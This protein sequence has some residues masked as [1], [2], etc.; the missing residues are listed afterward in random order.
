M[1]FVIGYKKKWEE[2]FSFQKII[3]SEKDK[4]FNYK[5]NNE[6]SICKLRKLL[7]EKNNFEE[8]N[9]EG[10]NLFDVNAF[11]IGSVNEIIIPNAILQSPFLNL[12][13]S[14]EYNLAFIGTTI[15]HELIHAFDD[16]GSKLDE[17]GNYY[18][19]WTKKDKEEYLKKQKEVIKKYEKMAS[20]DKIKLDG[21]LSLGEN[22]ADMFGLLLCEDVLEKYLLEKKIFGEKQDPY[23][24]RF[25]TY[26]S[27]SW[28][29]KMN[30]KYLKNR[31]LNDVHSLS[32]YRVNGVLSNSP[33]F[34]KVF[35]MNKSN[36][37]F[38]DDFIDIW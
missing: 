10:M 38:N 37:M 34:Q 11:Y 20:Q 14:F 29:N 12:H 35:E 17:K 27:I 3:Y 31:L 4:Y 13:K 21:K 33:R 25:F 19:W 26:Y 6:L 2:T 8:W 9:S 7:D 1:K 30:Y 28:K 22:I 23:F 36:S 24:K 16:E 15:G 32:K 5:K 18:N